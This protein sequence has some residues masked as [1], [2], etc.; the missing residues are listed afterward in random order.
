MTAAAHSPGVVILHKGKG[1]W[2]RRQLDVHSPDVTILHADASRFQPSCVSSSAAVSP[3]AHLAEH[4]CQILLTGAVGQ[5]AHVYH[6]GP[7]HG[8]ARSV[9]L[10]APT[11][12]ADLPRQELHAEKERTC[13]AL[14][15]G[16]LGSN[17]LAQHASSAVKCEHRTCPLLHVSTTPCIHK[18][19]WPSHCTARHACC[20]HTQR[21]ICAVVSRI[22]G[23][24]PLC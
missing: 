7:S 4:P 10:H 23:Q 2:P 1:R 13:C 18:L 12:H 15:S 11:V 16:W 22:A 3:G 20:T 17:G 21:N 19:S 6:S 24:R 8:V 14:R 9:V 5:V